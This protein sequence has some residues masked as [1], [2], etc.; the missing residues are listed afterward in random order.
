M[1]SQMTQLNAIQDKLTQFIEKELL[2]DQEIKNIGPSDPLFD[3]L[4]DSMGTLRLAVFVSD[5][6]GFEVA[7]GE[8]IP[9][10]FD[11]VEC[12][13]RYVQRKTGR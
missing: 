11:T 7:D 3:G 9:E 12:I 4:L 10:N 1:S 2:V 13:A 5:Q 6:F 8:L